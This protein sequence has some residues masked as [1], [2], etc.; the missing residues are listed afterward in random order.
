MKGE[1]KM[2]KKL[3]GGY[4]HSHNVQKPIS[5]KDLKITSRKVDWIIHKIIERKNE[6]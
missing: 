5:A 2:Q 1:E 4:T 6:T 3:K